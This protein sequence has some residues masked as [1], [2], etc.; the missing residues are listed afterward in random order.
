MMTMLITTIHSSSSK[1]Y[2][3]ENSHAV[4]QWH[5]HALH[6]VVPS[7]ISGMAGQAVLIKN[8]FLG[9][10]DM[11]EQYLNQYFMFQMYLG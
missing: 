9:L 6:A 5:S 8:I 7:S 1:L 10:G 4:A 2:I 3:L 11:V